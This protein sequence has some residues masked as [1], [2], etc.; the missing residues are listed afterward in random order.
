MGS[1][2]GFDGQMSQDLPA[3]A[4]PLGQAAGAAH[5][6][7]GEPGRVAREAGAGEKGIGAVCFLLHFSPTKNNYIYIY[8]HR[9]IY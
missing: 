8:I 3:G 6:V 9:N 7:R 5:Q 4:L 1:Q 2:N